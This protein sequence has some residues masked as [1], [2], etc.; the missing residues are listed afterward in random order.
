MYDTQKKALIHHSTLYDKV[1]HL[2][3]NKQT[4][5]ISQEVRVHTHERLI[6]KVHCLRQLARCLLLN[7]RKLG[8]EMVYSTVHAHNSQ[9]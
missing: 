4:I 3:E 2:S 8:K 7:K 6:V 9:T 5:K 1:L